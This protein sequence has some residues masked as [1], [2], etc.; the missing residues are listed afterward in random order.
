MTSAFAPSPWMDLDE[1]EVGGLVDPDGFQSNTEVVQG[2]GALG[3]LGAS[4]EVKGKTQKK[5][6]KI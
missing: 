5:V 4:E 6:E 2:P 3:A 1:I